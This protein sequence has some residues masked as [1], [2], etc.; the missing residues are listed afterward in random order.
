MNLIFEFCNASFDDLRN[1]RLGRVDVGGHAAGAIDHEDEISVWILLN[2]SLQKLLSLKKLDSRKR[3]TNKSNASLKI[4][5]YILA[6]LLNSVT[7]FMS[8][9]FGTTAIIQLIAN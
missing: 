7:K 6:T 2:H 9:A 4:N 5:S 3:D 1:L 8:Q